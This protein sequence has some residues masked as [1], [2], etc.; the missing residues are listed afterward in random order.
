MPKKAKKDKKDK[1]TSKEK[2][3][4]KSKKDK[5]DASPAPGGSAPDGAAG[6]TPA[7]SASQTPAFS[8]GQLFE[9]YSRN[10][11]IGIAE[12]QRLVESEQMKPLPASR[13]QVPGKQ[14]EDFEVGRLFERFSHTV[15][16]HVTLEEFGGLVRTLRGAGGIQP[17]LS[18]PQLANGG[19]APPPAPT[20]Y[21]STMASATSASNSVVPSSTSAASCLNE[22]RNNLWQQ[23]Q[24]QRHRRK[25]TGGSVGGGGG[26]KPGALS[27][28]DAPAADTSSMLSA[29]P[30]A[31]TELHI[32]SMNMMSKRDHLVQ[33]MRYVQ[34]RTEEVQSMRRAIERETVADTEAILHRLR[35]QEQFKLSLLNH[36]MAQLQHDI[37]EIDAFNE[38]L[39]GGRGAQ[40]GSKSSAN[41]GGDFGTASSV[42]TGAATARGRYLE[43]CAEAERIIGKPFKTECGTSRRF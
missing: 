40:G 11:T 7:A 9:R 28:T 8:A 37:D 20:S 36:D 2:K 41:G 3:P 30:L 5:G 10:G 39:R 27:K 12:F 16:G 25:N 32:L 31:S 19:S 34:A 18:A 21:A 22:L 15:P 26:M 42:I 17:T 29:L 1:K 33:Q 14:E 35:S 24:Q 38:E 23:Q 43:T 6:A 13:V 4:K